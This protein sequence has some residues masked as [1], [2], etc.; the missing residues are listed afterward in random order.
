VYHDLLGLCDGERRTPKFVRRYADLETESVQAVS[1]FVD[2]V[3][4]G[5][6]PSSAETYHMTDGLN[7][8][9]ELYGN[10][11]AKQMVG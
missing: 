9:L 10:A 4:T 11:A 8:A 7:Q 2:D 1:A 5:R 6:F 3:R